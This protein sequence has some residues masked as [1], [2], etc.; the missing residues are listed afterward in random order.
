VWS[1]EGVWAILSAWPFQGDWVRGFITNFGGAF[2]FI[3][4]LM[5]QFVR[6]SRQQATQDT[7]GTLADDL[8]GVASAVNAINTL[9]AREPTLQPIAKEIS[10]LTSTANTQLAQA[11]STV[12]TALSQMRGIPWDTAWEFPPRLTPNPKI[13]EPSPN[14][15]DL[16]PRTILRAQAPPKENDGAANK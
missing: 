2:F 15:S 4:W 1:C 16:Q 8:K 12:S 14:P 5:G 10:D 6:I 11:N 3:S 9:L 7:L 13:Y